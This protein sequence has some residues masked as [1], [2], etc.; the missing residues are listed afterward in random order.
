ME[1]PSHNNRGF[2]PNSTSRIYASPVEIP[3]G[4]HLDKRESVPNFNS[5]RIGVSTN[6][7]EVRDYG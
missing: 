1:V 5:R 4:R 7:R 6:L 3:K 2:N